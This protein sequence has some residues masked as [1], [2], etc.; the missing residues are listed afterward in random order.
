MD[1]QD[2]LVMSLVIKDILRTVAAVP[3]D[4]ELLAIDM[5][6]LGKRREYFRRLS[7]RREG[8]GEVERKSL[9]SLELERARLE[10]EKAALA[11]GGDPGPGTLSGS[12]RASWYATGEGDGSL[13]PL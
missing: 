1:A 4:E 13:D 5:A 8:L 2:G 3:A 12:I 9:R 10:R 6:K 7:L 11:E